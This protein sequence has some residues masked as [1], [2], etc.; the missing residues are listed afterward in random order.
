MALT[1]LNF[2]GS[3]TSLVASNI[4]T[5]TSAS[6]PANSVLQVV[7]SNDDQNRSL[8]QDQTTFILGC[9]ATITPSSTSSKILII[10]HG[11]ADISSGNYRA[12]RWSLFRGTTNILTQ[13]FHLYDANEQN[14]NMGVQP[15][16][17]LDSPNT[18]SA[19]TY[20]CS[21]AHRTGSGF[22]GTYDGVLNRYGE[23]SV[24][25]MEIKV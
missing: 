20:N 21:A 23:S 22:S 14:H 2:G 24:L 4:P 19:T 18:T 10:A 8:P 3:Q 13:D 9:Q 5:L 6:M 25:L 15:L 7:Q 11:A 16:M 12:I 17:F 1:K